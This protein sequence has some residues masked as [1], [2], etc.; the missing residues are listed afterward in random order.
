M[1]NK[2]QQ[3]QQQQFKGIVNASRNS[4][5]R[6]QK[7]RSVTRS[8][9]AASEYAVAAGKQRAHL[10]VASHLIVSISDESGAADASWE[11]EQEQEQEQ[12]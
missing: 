6:H 8:A 10:D 7:S 11:R 5:N 2:Q 9:E 1:S 4:Q 3:Q 12:E